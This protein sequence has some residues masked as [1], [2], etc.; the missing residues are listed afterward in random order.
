M[1][2]GPSNDQRNF[3]MLQFFHRDLKRVGFSFN[4]NLDVNKLVKR[5]RI[6]IRSRKKQKRKANGP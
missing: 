5:R 3:F 6:R 1:K 4:I 2:K